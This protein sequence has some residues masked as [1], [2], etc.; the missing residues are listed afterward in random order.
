MVPRSLDDSCVD[1]VWF[2]MLVFGG[3]KTLDVIRITIV[4]NPMLIDFVSPC[5]AILRMHECDKISFF[6]NIWF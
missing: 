4:A 3:T 5:H 2:A 6:D 1:L